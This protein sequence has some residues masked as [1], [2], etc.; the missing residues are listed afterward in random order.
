MQIRSCTLLRHVFA[1][2]QA[3]DTTLNRRVAMAY[4]RRVL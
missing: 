2:Y 4:A 3:T 1:I